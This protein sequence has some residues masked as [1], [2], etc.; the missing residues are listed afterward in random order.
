MNYRDMV[1]ETWCHSAPGARLEGLCQ[2]DAS[3]FE[4]VIEFPRE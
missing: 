4:L 1:G 3:T 2:F